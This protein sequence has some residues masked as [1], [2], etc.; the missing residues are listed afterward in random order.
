M[1]ARVRRGQPLVGI[2]MGSQSDYPT[3]QDAARILDKLGIPYEIRVVSAHRSPTRT[4]AYA[5]SARR[6]G[7]RVLIA[8]AGG[9]AHLAGVMA[10]LTTLP[11]LGVPMSTKALGG[12][13]SLLS[14][15]QMP[16]G[17]PV[18]TV[19]IGDARQAGLM[20]ARIVAM[21]SR[22]IAARVQRQT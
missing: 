22:T 14:T 10:A 20:A 21:S 2:I 9:A 7:L 3:M 13:D 1:R 17:V 18:G 19:G 12:M 11:V 15:L 4:A 16:S 8:G 6:R 5:S